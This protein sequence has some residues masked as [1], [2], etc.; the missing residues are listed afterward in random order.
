M[1]TIVLSADIKKVEITHQ[2][3]DYIKVEIDGCEYELKNWD[4]YQV[5]MLLGMINEI[6]VN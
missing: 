1:E 5:R 2:G 4:A 3:E 6:C